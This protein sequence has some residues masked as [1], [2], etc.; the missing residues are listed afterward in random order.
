MYLKNNL[1][2]NKA[3]LP[4]NIWTQFLNFGQS[5]RVYELVALLSGEYVVPTTYM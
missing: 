1:L 3:K 5:A 4:Y 2:I